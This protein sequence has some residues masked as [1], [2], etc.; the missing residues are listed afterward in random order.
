MPIM[1]FLVSLFIGLSVST[2][3]MVGQAYGRGDTALLKKIL[4]NSFMTILI[5]CVTMALTGLLFSR[6]ML[7]LLGTPDEILEDAAVFLSVIFLGMIFMFFHN[8]ISGV[9]RGLGDSGSP[10]MFTFIFVSLNI[11]LAPLLI[12]G[13]FIVPELG[14]AGS[15][16]ATAISAFITSIIAAVYLARKNPVFNL[17]KWNYRPD[18][19]VIKKMFSIGIPVSVQM[20]IASIGGIILIFFVNRFG[21]ETIA[22]Y[23]IGI[24]IDQFSFIIA[25]SLGGSAASAFSAQAIGMKKYEKIKE[26]TKWVIIITMSF[27]LL[28]FII[29][30]LLPAAITSIFT[31][32]AK[33]IS[34]T[35]HYFRF[36]TFSYFAYSIMFTYQGIIRGSGDTLPATLFAFI[37]IIIFRS[38]TAWG[39]IDFAGMNETGIWIAMLIGPYIGALLNFLYYK[40]GKWKNKGI[41]R[42]PDEIIKEDLTKESI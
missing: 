37:T 32:D 14:I 27:A 24:R 15:A 39:L 26:V 22:A 8:W 4:S 36:A 31:G 33:V 6:D 28:F 42:P 29:V 35:V 18:F 30:N 7:V 1:F 11:V 16:L 40:S 25:M 13:F 2:V 41:I 20:M 23:G 34:K 5:L 21:P 17:L 38:G 3:I 10:L 12:T 19:S 9:L